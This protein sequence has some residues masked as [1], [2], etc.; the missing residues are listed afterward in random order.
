MV[1]NLKYEA[2]WLPKPQNLALNPT[3]VT[4]NPKPL[5]HKPTYLEGQGI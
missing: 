1:E 2:Y 3:A 5:S 4:L